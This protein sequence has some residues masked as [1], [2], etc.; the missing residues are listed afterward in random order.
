MAEGK[1]GGGRHLNYNVATA[2][3]RDNFKTKK[4]ASKMVGELCTS[5]QVLEYEMRF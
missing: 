1:G 4:K 3:C 2:N 5:F